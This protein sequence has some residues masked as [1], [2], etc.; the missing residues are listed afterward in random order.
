MVHYVWTYLRVAE[1]K[2]WVLPN[3]LASVDIR[4][5]VDFILPTGAMGNIASGYMV[6]R[7]GLPVG[8]LVAAVNVNDIIH[9]TFQT[10]AFHRSD[11]LHRTLSEAINIQ[12]P[13]NFERLVYLTDGNAAVVKSWYQDLADTSRIDLNAGWLSRLQRDLNSARVT[14]EQ[15]CTAAKMVYSDYKYLTDPHTAVAFSAAYQ[16]GYLVPGGGGSSGENKISNSTDG[17]ELGAATTHTTSG[18]T[19]LLATA[20]PCK[21]EHSVTTA[22]GSEIWQEYFASDQFPAAAKRILDLPE[23]PPIVYPAGT[24][25]KA[26][27]RHWEELARHLVAK[28][29]Q[30]DE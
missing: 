12:V 18:A 24:N 7:M 6:Q 19:A 1:Q 22:V 11:T 21:F 10:G 14:D 23:R 25:L 30:H 8:K 15:M 28:L 20:S 5:K 16:L 3:D 9:T 2:R 27:Q 17:N 29:E 4:I 26:T 13:Y